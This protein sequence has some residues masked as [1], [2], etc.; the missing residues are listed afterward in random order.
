ML[1]PSDEWQDRSLYTLTGP[2]ID[3]IQHNI[4]INAE[5]LETHASA[6]SASYLKYTVSISG[7]LTQYDKPKHVRRSDVCPNS[8][9]SWATISG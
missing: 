4:T 7:K 6:A 2:T 8:W 1:L 3:G 9:T 5:A